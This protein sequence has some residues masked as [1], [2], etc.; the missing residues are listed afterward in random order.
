MILYTEDHN[1]HVRRYRIFQYVSH[2]IG[3]RWAA[4]ME[5]LFMNM[6]GENK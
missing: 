1:S 5:D 4:I 2:K 3:L 6:K